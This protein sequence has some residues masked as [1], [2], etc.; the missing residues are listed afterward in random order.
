MQEQN[1]NRAGRVR[2]SPDRFFAAVDP[3]EAAAVGT[4]ADQQQQ[5]EVAAGVWQQEGA[6]VEDG[7]EEEEDVEAGEELWAPYQPQQE[8]E[9]EG[10]EEEDP[11]QAYWQ[12]AQEQEE[13]SYKPAKHAWGRGVST[14]ELPSGTLGSPGGGGG[15]NFG[16]GGGGG[17]DWALATPSALLKPRSAA[18]QGM[19]LD[20]KDITLGQRLGGGAFATVYAA[21]MAGSKRK[22][23]VKRLD[24]A[25]GS[26]VSQVRG[27]GV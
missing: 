21:T 11:R 3:S 18:A 2:M 27:Q 20:P 23:V 26:Q 8:G 15:L 12:Q 13:D 25:H 10:G 24:R 22:W 16:I 5:Q 6:G 1:N 7:M 9:E 14:L 19:E 4:E 17:A